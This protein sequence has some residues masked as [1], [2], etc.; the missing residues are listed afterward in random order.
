MNCWFTDTL[1]DYLHLIIS[2]MTTEALYIFLIITKCHSIFRDKNMLKWRTV[3]FG[4][5]WGD[6]MPLPSLDVNLMPHLSI[7]LAHNGQPSPSVCETLCMQIVTTKIE[8]EV[9]SWI[10]YVYY[11]NMWIILGCTISNTCQK[12]IKDFNYMQQFCWASFVVKW[13]FVCRRGNWHL[14]IFNSITVIFYCIGT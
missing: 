10:L 4:D 7:S 11:N 3:S 8:K 14:L 2:V 5:G 12:K 6:V 13:M 1:R 9:V